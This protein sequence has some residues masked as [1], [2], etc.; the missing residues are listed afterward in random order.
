MQKILKLCQRLVNPGLRGRATCTGRSGCREPGEEMENQVT[1]GGGEG[2]SGK[3]EKVCTLSVFLRHSSVASSTS[4]MFSCREIL[5][6]EYFLHIIQ[7][8]PTNSKN[9]LY[10][11]NTNNTAVWTW[12]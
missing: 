6:T 7:L 5:K 2:E 3:K 8:M 1:A 12:T 4:V 10:P 11:S 9:P